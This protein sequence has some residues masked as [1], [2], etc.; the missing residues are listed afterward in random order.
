M[1]VPDDRSPTMAGAVAT[2]EA[3]PHAAPTAGERR[4]G[5]GN[6]HALPH[7]TALDGIRAFAAVAVMGVHQQFSWMPGGFYGVDA[8][9]T[10]SGFLI[11][12]LLVREVAGTGT[13][14]LGAFWARRARR[15]LPALLLLVLVVGLVS[16]FDPK[17][18]SAPSFPGALATLFYSA[19]WYFVF[20]HVNYFAITGAPSPLL[21]TWSLAIEEQFYLLWPVLVLVVIRFGH[22]RATAST[23]VFEQHFRRRM[24]VLL[25]IAAA[26]ALASAASMWLVTGTGDPTAAYYGTGTRAQGV[27]TG[28]A[29]ALCFA[30][31]GRPRRRPARLALALASLAGVGVTIL[32]WVSVSENSEVAFHGGFL[33]ASLA[34]GAVVANVASYPRSLTG[35]FLSVWPLRKLGIISYGVYLWYWPVILAM[36]P[37]RLH[38]GP[39]A[40]FGARFGVTVGIAILSY[41]LV[42]APIR[43]GG[44]SRRT[45][46]WA[47]PAAMGLAAA[48]MA[49]AALVPPASGTHLEIRNT[50]L[51]SANPA[52]ANHTAL[53]VLLVGD[54]A[55]GSLG[56]GLGTAAPRYGVQLMNQG[57]PGCSVSLTGQDKVLWYTVPPGQ[58]CSTQ[59]PNALLNEWKRLVDHYNPDVVVYLARSD[60]LDQQVA[61]HWEHV[62]QP[63]FDTYL[64][65]RLSEA[66]AVL[67]SRGASV[68]LMTEPY[69]EAGNSPAD[70][71]PED[72]PS[73]VLAADRIIREVGAHF[74]ARAPRSGSLVAESTGPVKPGSVAGKT[75]ADAQAALPQVAVFNLGA[76]ISPGNQ[77]VD[78]VNG[79]PTRCTDGVHFTEPGGELVAR[80]LFPLVRTLGKDHHVLSPGGQWPGPTP[81]TTPD[82]WFKLPCS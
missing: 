13:V 32:L 30:L 64:R 43:Y 35:R 52:V 75:V 4:P 62:G 23:E 76:M 72:D 18:I 61:G 58:P 1:V 2:L 55:A 81:P 5:S 47:I 39:Y 79:V 20:Q 44:M 12:S 69:Y 33:M 57:H 37:E 53:K 28:A 3:P 78:D 10:L 6:A 15:L 11:T 56:V 60:L 8:F 17:L 66:V 45:T 41:V 80:Q 54:S 25:A 7:V 34:A 73:R 65:W 27:L 36:S 51:A 71:W 9:F 38:L 67:S 70:S 82:W 26:G 19:N 68:V 49:V 50:A 59:D 42:E 48:A 21:H 40:L 74:G 63:A 31:W 77:F 16:A 22:R 24:G 29:I 14:R 46:A